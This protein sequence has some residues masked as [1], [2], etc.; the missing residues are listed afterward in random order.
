MEVPLQPPAAPRPAHELAGLPQVDSAAS[1]VLRPHLFASRD[2]VKVRSLRSLSTLTRPRSAHPTATG[3]RPAPSALGR[4]FFPEEGRFAPIGSSNEPPLLRK[5]CR[6]QAAGRRTLG[7]LGNVPLLSGQNHWRK[8]TCK[9]KHQED[10]NGQQD[11]TVS[12]LL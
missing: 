6:G 11:K 12:A 8:G 4:S 1:A 2:R 7:E 9:R 3:L 5:D 10:H